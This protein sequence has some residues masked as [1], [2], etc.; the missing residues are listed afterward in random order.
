M[1]EVKCDK[2]Y[3]CSSYGSSKCERCKHNK[4]KKDYFE[5]E[6]N[7]YI[8]EPYKWPTPT[9]PT[10]TWPKDKDWIITCYTTKY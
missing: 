7:W 1:T 10:Q 2:K 8:T 5:P 6:N 3:K 9:R 4:S